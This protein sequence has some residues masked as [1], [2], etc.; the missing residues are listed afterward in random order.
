MGAGAHT[1]VPWK[2]NSQGLLTSKP[3]LQVQDT[4]LLI[5][6]ISHHV[7]NLLPGIKG[8]IS[9]ACSE[10]QAVVVVSEVFFTGV[11]GE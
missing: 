4:E 9:M 5:F 11:A 3:S 7:H 2:S 6:M 8:I 1:Q 10:Y